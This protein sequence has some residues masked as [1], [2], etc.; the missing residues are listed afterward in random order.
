MPLRNITGPY[1]SAILRFAIR[2]PA[3]YPELPPLVTFNTDIFHPLVVPLTTYTFTTG[4]SNETPV[5]ATDEERLSPGA[6]SL[7]H[8]FPHWFGRAQRT[9]NNS[10][11]PS[12]NISGSKIE[13]EEALNKAAENKTTIEDGGDSSNVVSDPVAPVTPKKQTARETPVTSPSPGGATVK[14]S[15]SPASPAQGSGPYLNRQKSVPVVTLLNYIRSTF[16][17]ETILDSLPLDAAGNPGAWHAWKAYRRN[18]K[19]FKRQSNGSGVAT[20]NNKSTPQARLPGEWNWEGVWAKRVQSGVEASQSHAV[21]FGNAP[22]AG[23]DLV[24]LLGHILAGQF[25]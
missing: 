7:R 6:F 9:A 17:D 22:R 8:G 13:N 15:T 20:P 4:S 14:E 12:R 21:L 25:R 10:G 3:S 1:A 11:T 5:S 16:D 19:G 2:F 23:D 18:A 24:S